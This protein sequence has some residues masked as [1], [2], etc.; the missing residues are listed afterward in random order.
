MAKLLPLVVSSLAAAGATDEGCANM[1]AAA[2]QRWSARFDELSAEVRA[3]RAQVGIPEAPSTDTA[4]TSG[5]SVAP[6]RSGYLYLDFKFSS[7]L[8]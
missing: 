1:L 5:S 7:Y 8:L 2:E 3:L 4:A 6:K